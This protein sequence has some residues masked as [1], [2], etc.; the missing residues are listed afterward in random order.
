MAVKS[1]DLGATWRHA[2]PVSLEWIRSCSA[3]E[4]TWGGEEY[5][6][7]NECRATEVIGQDSS[8]VVGLFLEEEEFGR[9]ALS[10]H[11][12]MDLLLPRNEACVLG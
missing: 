9:V 3:G 7:N 12:T 10:C 5:E 8:E 1:P 2:C 11:M 6:H 4:T